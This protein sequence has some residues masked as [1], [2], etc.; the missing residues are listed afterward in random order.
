MLPQLSIKMETSTTQRSPLGSGTCS[1]LGDRRFCACGCGGELVRPTSTSAAKFKKQ[2]YIK[3][4]HYGQEE[5]EQKKSEGIMKAHERG[6]FVE[7][8]KARKAKTMENRPRC[9]CG[10][11]QP[12]RAARALY[13]RG[14]F[15]ATTPENQA[16]ARAARDMEKLKAGNSVRL[17]AQMKEWKDSGKLD[18]I[19]RKAG[20]AMGQLDH[21]GA[22]V[23]IIRDTY[24]RIYKF[25]NMMEWARKN[26]HLFEDD[27]PESKAPFWKRIAEGIYSLLD[28]DGR[29]CSYRGW[30]AVSKLE[31]DAGGADLLGRD[32]FM[33]NA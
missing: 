16:K 3:G 27:R 13:A 25:S 9:K 24:G 32:Y 10:C 1:A 28:D 7:G 29:S 11:G 22:K 5:V 12:V 2:R 17:A 6:A 4:H 26:E 31:L 23:W 14:C 20:N 30:T 8:C 21:I 18:E 15:D 33:Q 19:R